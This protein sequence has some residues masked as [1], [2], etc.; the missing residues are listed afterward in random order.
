MGLLKLFDHWFDF[1]CPELPDLGGHSANLLASLL[2]M[3]WLV[4][5]RD[6]YTGGHLWR[7]SM[8]ARLLA[9][10]VGLNDADAA[11]FSLGGFLHDLGKVS[12]P[13]AILRK[14]DALTP[15]EYAIIKT[16]PE[17]GVRMLAGHPLAGLV[18]DAI[19]SHHERPDGHGYPD[20]LLETGIPRIAK[21]VGVCDAFDAMTSERPYRHGMAPAEACAIIRK[22]AG[23]QFSSE[24]SSQFVAMCEEGLFDCIVGYSDHGIPLQTCPR[25]GPTLTIRREQGAGARVYCHNCGAEFSLETA[26]GRVVVTPTGAMGNA[27]QLQIEVDSMLISRTVR[28]LAEMLPMLDFHS[29]Q[30]QFVGQTT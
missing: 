12:V 20:R 14:T 23:A 26:A 21:V 17:M 8:Y 27:E 13:D 1:K 22:L 5:A 11:R 9:E 28:A 15:S 3:A 30:S 2:T 24:Y 7:V 6:P 19:R 16:H 25:C 18:A 29:S 4:E 10:R